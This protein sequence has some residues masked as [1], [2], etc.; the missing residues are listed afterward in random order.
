[1]NK[2]VG[3]M[4]D[5]LICGSCKRFFPSSSGADPACSS[6]LIGILFPGLKWLRC[7]ADHLSPYS[8]EVKNEYSSTPSTFRL[9]VT[10]F[11]L[12]VLFNLYLTAFNLVFVPLV[13]CLY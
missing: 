2:A 10:S 9:C 5:I 4:V 7:E 12:S 3:W 11:V 13:R 6:V 1:M 8:S